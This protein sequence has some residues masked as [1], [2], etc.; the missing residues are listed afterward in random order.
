MIVFVQAYNFLE[1]LATVVAKVVV[2]RHGNL[3]VEKS[4][5]SKRTTAKIVV[6]SRDD[7]RKF[8]LLKLLKKFTAAAMDGP[9][10]KLF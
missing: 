8:Q 9:C 5:I 6:L 2:H 10:K 3:P 4:R 7:G 1:F